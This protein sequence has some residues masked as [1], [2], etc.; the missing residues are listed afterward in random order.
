[1][2]HV[3]SNCY[4]IFW[5]RSVAYSTLV[6]KSKDFT[7]TDSLFNTHHNG[8]EARETNLSFPTR[9]SQPQFAQS[10]YWGHIKKKFHRKWNFEDPPRW[11]KYIKKPIKLP[12]SQCSLK[13]RNSTRISMLG[14][15]VLTYTLWD[16]IST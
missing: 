15:L 16:K 1:M 2:Q 12:L 7:F 14:M 5:E 6:K 8:D 13:W 9:L 3:A 10:L 11:F 4:F